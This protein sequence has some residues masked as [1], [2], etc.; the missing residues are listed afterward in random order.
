MTRGILSCT[1]QQYGHCELIESFIR[2]G[3]DPYN[4]DHSQRNCLH[5]AVIYRREDAVKV[6][7]Q[8][9]NNSRYDTVD[10]NGM[11][12]EDYLHESEEN[13]LLK[14]L[15]GETNRIDTLLSRYL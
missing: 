2:N 14:Y 13:S 9:G 5:Y 4:T 3:L 11:R 8:K 6:L 15:H 1:L 10:C 7:L 12:P